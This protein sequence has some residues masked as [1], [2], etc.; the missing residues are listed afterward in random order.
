MLRNKLTVSL[1]LLAIAPVA[2]AHF[3]FVVP[4]ADHLTAKVMMTEDLLPADGIPASIVK[5]A[6]LSLH[7]ADGKET[8][9]PMTAGATAYTIAIPASDAARVVHGELDLGVT[10]RGQA[11]PY[12]LVY[13]PKTI[14]GNPFDAS[15]N[16]GLAATPIEI[17]PAGDGQSLWFTVAIDGKPAPAGTE[18]HVIK[19]DGSQEVYETNDKGSTEAFTAPGRY[20]AW[21]K[22]VKTEAGTLDGKAY[23]ETR[24]YA[25]LVIDNGKRPA[26]V[27][28]APATQPL[29]A[30]RTVTPLPEAVASF[31]AVASDGYLYVYGGH[32]AVTHS[33]DTSAVSKRFNRLSL[34]D[35]AAKWEELPGGP[36]IQGMNLAA[37]KG[38][39]YRVGGME[40]RN[41]P[42]TEADNYSL[43]QAAVFD[44]QT[45]QWTALP[46]LPE[47]RSSHDVAV[48][49]GKLYVIG[50]WTMNGEKEGN[51]WPENMLV[52][53]LN[54]PNP[55]WDEIKQP[56]KR[57][58]LIVAAA[59]RK[60]YVFGGFTE[61]SDPSKNV[62]VYDTA[63]GTWSTAPQLPGDAMNGFA[64][65]AVARGNELLV[66]VGDG[67]LYR[68]DGN[69]WTKVAQT[70][71]RIVHRLAIHGPDI[72]VLGGAAHGKNFD[73]VE[74][75]ALPALAVKGEASAAVR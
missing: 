25:T 28:A 18:V 72:L 2:R 21:A 53:D 16:L 56:F 47:G 54:S 52:M 1:L 31:G 29:G 30:V 67:S 38:K 39:I 57:R 9:L 4:D 49:D 20:G 55:K 5:D 37:Y 45:K 65:A 73:L 46:D 51:D 33:Y 34:T 23:E 10:K 70:T 24:H 8:P 61:D 32:T 35:A 6:K 36:G 50:G 59:G 14:V 40:P 3:L 12:H 71:P 60:I 74:A 68:L 17:S 58:A 22:S 66:S 69:A 75:V 19:P 26:V 7:T 13:H 48:V 41:A 62:D 43:K 64:P 11:K 27:A 63:T 15:T 44:P 42:G